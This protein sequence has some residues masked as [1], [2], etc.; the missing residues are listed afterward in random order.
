ML[1][2]LREDGPPRQERK[3]FAA[4]TGASIQANAPTGTERPQAESKKARQRRGKST[5]L[6]KVP[7]SQTGW[8]RTQSKS[9]PSPLPNSL[10]TGKLTGISVKSARVSR[11][12]TLILEQNY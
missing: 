12:R 11:F 2:L 8:W 7:D 6:H 4:E 5:S 3:F 1:P 9:N 10:L